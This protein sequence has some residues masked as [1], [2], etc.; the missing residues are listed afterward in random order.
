MNLGE[1][2][3]K[4]IQYIREYSNDGSLTPSAD[5][6]DYLLSMNT[7]ANDAQEEI[8]DKLGI[9][10]SYEIEKEAETGTGYTKYDLPADF[11]EHR[12]INLDDE[13][14]M[15]YRIE[16]G[17][18]LVPKYIYGTLEHFY[19][20]KPTEITNDTA[21]SHSFEVAETSAIPFYMAAMSVTD[22][23]PETAD[24]LLSMY[25]M[26][27]ARLKRKNNTFPNVTIDVYG[28]FEG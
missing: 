26:K 12:H 7:F 17:K 2:K 22:E 18:L 3:T 5:N 27:I 9:E 10:A 11:K 20:K 24:Q 25:Q 23:K 1:A 6:Q 19:Y 4:A 21:D 13:I 14:F 16:N 15:N 28:G 8:A